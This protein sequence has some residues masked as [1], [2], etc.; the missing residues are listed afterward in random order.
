MQLLHLN[1]WPMQLRAAGSIRPQMVQV[2]VLRMPMAL[3]IN[4]CRLR[5]CAK[6]PRDHYRG[7]FY[8]WISP[9]PGEPLH[10]ASCLR[11]VEYVAGE[12]GR[13]RAQNKHPKGRARQGKT[14]AGQQQRRAEASHPGGE[15]EH[16]LCYA[17][18]RGNQDLS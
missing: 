6:L 16:V 8:G 11:Q 17:R 13:P 9:P 1:C 5:P 4:G 12:G 18:G 3:G 14:P 7:D 10:G 15:T 2:L